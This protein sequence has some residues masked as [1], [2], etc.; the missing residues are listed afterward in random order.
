MAVREYCCTLWWCVRNGPDSW[1]NRFEE[2]AYDLTVSLTWSEV[3][4]LL[5]LLLLLSIFGLFSFFPFPSSSWFR[6]DVQPNYGCFVAVTFG[7]F[8]AEAQKFCSAVQTKQNAFLFLLWTI[9][10]FTL[11]KSKQAQIEFNA[12]REDSSFSFII[13]LTKHPHVIFPS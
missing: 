8:V 3:S 10:R 11:K 1:L 6:T 2:G 9:I 7:C 5:L 13:P 4:Y 12:V